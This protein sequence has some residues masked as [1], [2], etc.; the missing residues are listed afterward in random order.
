MFALRCLFTIAH[1]VAMAWTWSVYFRSVQVAREYPLQV[2][3]AAHYRPMPLT[4][5]V[6]STAIA[7]A[8]W[9]LL[10]RAA[11]KRDRERG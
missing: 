3:S 7:V 11:F 1:S 5:P 10:V 9:I 6:L 4:T 8:M 2:L